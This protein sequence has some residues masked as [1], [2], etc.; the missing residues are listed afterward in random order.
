MENSLKLDYS[1]ALFSVS[2]WFTMLN[3]LTTTEE[4]PYNWQHP[5]LV[6]W[7]T[8]QGKDHHQ[9]LTIDE[10]CILQMSLVKKFRSLLHER[11]GGQDAA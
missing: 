4:L 8:A 6:E 10:I 1:D 2:C 7:M 9:D 11:I 5:I 3:Q